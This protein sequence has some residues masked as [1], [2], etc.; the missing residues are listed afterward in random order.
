M[1]PLSSD[2]SKEPAKGVSDSDVGDRDRERFEPREKE[3]DTGGEDLNIS[4]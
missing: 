1:R 2:S 4:G 3:L